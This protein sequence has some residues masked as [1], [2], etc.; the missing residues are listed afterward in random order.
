MSQAQLHIIIG[1]M[2]SGKSTELLKVIN[3]YKILEKNL[4]IINHELDKRYGDGI[5]SHDKKSCPSHSLSVLMDVVNNDSYKD[6]DVVIIEEAQFFD[7]LMEFV[8]H[9]LSIN[10]II[11]VAGLDGD[12]FMKPFG[13]ILELVP[14]CDTIKKLSA[15]C[16]LC[17]DGT[18]ANFTKRIVENKEQKLIGS[19][20]SF[21][22]V[23]RNH[24]SS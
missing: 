14:M 16:V 7:D 21:I 3:Y 11:Y 15:L 20:E 10:K 18:P 23:C 1:C 19:F 6:C 2:Y 4:F 5:V 22:P 9:S 12:S 8:K 17:K 24:H 13:S